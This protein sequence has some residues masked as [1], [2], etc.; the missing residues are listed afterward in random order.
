MRDNDSAC[1]REGKKT[2]KACSELLPSLKEAQK[3]STL[4]EYNITILARHGRAEEHHRARKTIGPMK[5]SAVERVSFES[6]EIVMAPGSS[7]DS[8]KIFA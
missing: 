1:C 6:I 7:G 8:P 2:Q 4:M 5:D 3:S